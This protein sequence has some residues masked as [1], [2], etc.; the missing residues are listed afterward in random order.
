MNRRFSAPLVTFTLWV[1]AT[2]CAL[3]TS[4]PTVAA[5]D[6]K[7]GAEYA[8]RWD[9]AREGPDTAE[10][11]LQSLGATAGKVSNYSVR[12]FKIVP[13]QDAP[14]GFEPILRERVKDNKYELTFKYRGDRELASW[15]CPLPNPTKKESEVDVT[16]LEN[17]GVKRVRSYTCSIEDSDQ[18]IA[19]PDS[20][21][22]AANDSTC[23]MR[24]T[25]TKADDKL[26]IEEWHFPGD[27]RMI[28]VSRK[29][30]DT[31]EDLKS[32]QIEIVKKLSGV[33]PADRSKTES[34][35]MK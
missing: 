6:V 29:G 22:A 15:N 18:P 11:T 5:G 10:G 34:C 4:T 9:I 13:P 33:E 20:L 25:K 21:K 24:R 7:E 32:F 2:A 14:A 31:E 30:G 1:S 19:I 27:V 17:N 23:E 35:Q 8:V 16:I 28:E 3:A 26:K 12:Y